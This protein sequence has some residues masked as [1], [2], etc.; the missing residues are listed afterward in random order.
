MSG[1]E[2]IIAQ[3][4]D[5]ARAEADAILAGAKERAEAYR[6]REEELL[7]RETDAENRKSEKKAALELEKRRSAALM[8][9]KKQILSAKQR[10]ISDVIE[11]AKQEVLSMPEDAYFELLYQIADAC[12]QSG[13]GQV[14]LSEKDLKRL[15][16]GFGGK[17]DAIARKHGAVLTVSQKPAEI[18]GGLILDYGDIEENG[19]IEA[20]ICSK[21]ETLQDLVSSFLFA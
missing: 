1:L 16:A 21:K 20:L 7:A 6:K 15:P 13:T 14:L 18:E 4:T 12:A 9:Q 5:D 2:T 17:M 19:T 10:M 3:I 11:K 8:E